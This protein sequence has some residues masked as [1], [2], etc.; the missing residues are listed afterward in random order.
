MLT[1]MCR[2]SFLTTLDIYKTYFKGSHI[3]EYKENTCKK[4]LNALFSPKRS[5]CIF[6][7]QGFVTKCFLIFIVDE[8]KNFA[9]NIFLKLV[10]QSRTGSRA[11]LVSHVLGSVQKGDVHILKCSEVLKQQKVSIVSSSTGIVE[12]RGK[13]F[14]LD[15]KLLFI[16]V[17]CFSG[18][19]LPRFFYCETSLFHWFSQVIISYLI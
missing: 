13:G 3:R 12:S 15:L 8:V 6:A 9:A 10:W 19:F 5:Y 2:V 18:M 17:D 14:V 11:S 4:W 16:I 7:S 1:C